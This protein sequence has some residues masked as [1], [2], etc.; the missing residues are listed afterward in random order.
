MEA[1]S[2]SHEELTTHSS[3]TKKYFVGG[4]L[5]IVA[6]IGFVVLLSPKNA[7]AKFST[8]F[9]DKAPQVGAMAT[10]DGKIITD[11]E[12][13]GRELEYNELLKKIYELRI[14]RL[15][16]IAIEKL[17]A[18]EAAK[19]G[20]TVDDY[21]NKKVLSAITISEAEVKKF[22][23][24]KKIEESQL[25]PQ[26]R[27]RVN[28]YL[29]ATKRQDALDAYLSKL[30]AGNPIEVYFTKPIFRVPVE[31]GKGPSFGPE[32]A[33]ISI[34]VFSDFQCPFCAKG[35]DAVTAL[36]KKYGS[37]IRVTFR[38]YP[39]PMHKDARPAAEASLCVADQGADKFWKFHDLAFANQSKLDAI[40][41][42]KFAKDVGADGK[43][44]ADCI[45]KKKHADTVV[46]D[47]EY[48]EKIGVK[49]TPT[50]FING[51]WISGALPIEQFSEV[52]DE[53]LAAKH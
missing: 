27:E 1:I 41:L 25:N 6:A 39:L 22:L 17:S 48:G 44:Y 2:V 19:A 4:V 23:A 13:V 10:I 11:E 21:L 42:E 30:T 12:L 3:L 40:S 9:K 33:P 31:A 50:F 38:Q 16:H 35:A 29:V 52:I 26:M 28:A 37:K 24:E 36:K 49:S 5:V 51:Q 15:K 46:K 18:I 14:E 43:Q 8:V 7:K 34:V 20:L 53:E 47:T 32:N 45:Q